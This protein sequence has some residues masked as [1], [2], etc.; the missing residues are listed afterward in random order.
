MI[1][2]SV[3]AVS[4]AHS[5]AKICPNDAAPR[6]SIRLVRPKEEHSDEETPLDKG[7]RASRLLRATRRR[8]SINRTRESILRILQK[9]SDEGAASG[10]NSRATS[11]VD[12]LL[13]P[14]DWLTSP[15]YEPSDDRRISDA[16][17]RKTEIESPQYGL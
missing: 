9:T 6:G 16:W 4:S 7:E 15:V 5:S 13:S 14:S 17:A 12:T 3:R 8:S 11:F 10:N 1:S 2:N